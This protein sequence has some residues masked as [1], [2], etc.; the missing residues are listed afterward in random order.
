MLDAFTSLF[1]NEMYVIIQIMYCYDKVETDANHSAGS[2]S[3]SWS[4]FRVLLYEMT[5][6]PLNSLVT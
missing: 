1:F 2:M 6:I 5:V 3:V 4:P